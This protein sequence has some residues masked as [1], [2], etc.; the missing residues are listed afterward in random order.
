MFF[1]APRIRTLREPRKEPLG[2]HRF[3]FTINHSTNQPPVTI[4]PFREETTRIIAIYIAEG[5][6]RELNVSARDRIA[7]LRTLAQTTHP[8]AF[9]PLRR[10]V[11]DSLRLQAHPNFIRWSIRNGSTP[12]VVFAVGLGIVTIVAG[13]LIAVLLTLSGRARAWRALAAVAWVVGI[14]VLTAAS[15]GMCVVC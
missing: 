15:R 6:P 2:L 13:F 4:Q 8:S 10:A 3:P 1:S 5:S 14:L 7:A 11:E 9:G 12:R